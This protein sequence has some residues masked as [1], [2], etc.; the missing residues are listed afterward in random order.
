MSYIKELYINGFKKFND[1]RIS[2]NKNINII[3]GENERGKSTILEAI[4]IV[5][6]QRYRNTDKYIIREL[7]SREQIEKF[8]KKPTVSNLPKIYIEVE[9]K[10]KGLTPKES[11]YYG[12]NNINNREASGITFMCEFDQD[13]LDELLP[14]IMN[15]KIPYE[16]YKLDWKTFAGKS[17]NPYKKIFNTILIDSSTLDSNSAFN[18]YNKSLF[19]AKHEIED[20]LRI[21]DMFRNELSNLLDKTDINSFNE[22]SKNIKFGINNK[23]VILDNILTIYDDD[24][25]I[26][27]KGKG[28]ENIIK[29]NIALKK[30]NFEIDT[31]LLEEPENHLSHSNLLRMIEDLCNKSKDSQLIVTTHESLIASRL[32]LRNII[33]IADNNQP[34]RLDDIEKSTAEYFIRADDQKLLQFLLANKVIL[35]E[36]ATEYLLIPKFYKQIYNSTLEEDGISI[37][38]CGGV[39]YKRYFE[40]AKHVDKKVCVIT[41]NDKKKELI[42]NIKKINEKCSNQR[43]FIESDINIW[44]WEVAIYYEN[45]EKLKSIIDVKNS[46]Y[47]FKGESYK[48]NPYLGKMLNNKVDVALEMLKDDYNNW[49]IPN[50]VK[51]ALEWIR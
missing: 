30:E 36:G 8:K 51:E 21:R 44:T 25:P 20:R 7:L 41:D 16:Y 37:I 5:I 13:Y 11:K 14:S 1:L 43:I 2:F 29:T 9:L 4:D 10:M 46:E 34:M 27:N 23:K 26:E 28:M 19:Y 12:C 50:Y 48:E 38:S 15:G 42:K 6:N 24:I 40:I 31:V 3:V 49:K 45:E 39:T 17:Y 47:E 35:V 32:D 22:D 18:Y 33:W